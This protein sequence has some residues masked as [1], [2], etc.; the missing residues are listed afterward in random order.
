MEMENKTEVENEFRKKISL[1]KLKFTSLEL[2]N[3]YSMYKRHDKYVPKWTRML[4]ISLIVIVLAR[5]LEI[6]LLEI[7]ISEYN[8]TDGTINSEIYNISVLIIGIACE[9]VVFFWKKLHIIRGLMLLVSIFISVA[10]SSHT[11][12]MRLSVMDN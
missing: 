9:I 10:Y 11:D 3:N 1:K 7:Y 8:A 2:E 6:L 12:F 4:I 5:R